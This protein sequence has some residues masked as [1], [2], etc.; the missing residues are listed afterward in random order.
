M[1]NI[2]QA[3]VTIIDNKLRDNG[4]AK[5]AIKDKDARSLLVYA[6]EACVGEIEHGADNHGTFVELCQKTVDN[7][8]SGESWCM[9]F[10]QSMIAYVETK[11]SIQSP[12]AS[13]ENCLQVWELT[14][15]SQIVENIPKKG[16]IIIWRHADN[17]T[18][19]SINP[20]TTKR[21]FKYA[22]KGHTG[23]VIEYDFD[24]SVKTM[25][26]VEGNTN[27]LGSSN[28]DGVFK[29]T[30][31]NKTKEKGKDYLEVIGFL[32]PFKAI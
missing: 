24:N 3:L 5:K 17:S 23:F 1:R 29:K 16:A 18:K 14:P 21:K 6:A 28:G 27:K 2:K 4:S 10:V 9:G 19:K 31:R 25:T 11:L 32:I 26:T 20:E 15:E 7:I 22:G 30:N 12:L 13:S 8:A